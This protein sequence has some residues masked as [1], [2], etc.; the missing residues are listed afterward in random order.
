M[1]LLEILTTA[2]KVREIALRVSGNDEDLSEII[3]I[4]HLL[5][6]SIDLIE[7]EKEYR[8][9]QIVISTVTTAIRLA[10]LFLAKAKEKQ[11]SLSSFDH[12]I[13]G[14]LEELKLLLLKEFPQEQKSQD[15]TAHLKN[16]DTVPCQSLL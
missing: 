3:F 12:L 2:E 14:P 4:S 5:N 16:S 11:L 1:N 13:S 8:C 15:E 9:G 7:V 10:E 6:N